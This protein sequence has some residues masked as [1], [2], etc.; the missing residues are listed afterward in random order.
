MASTTTFSR[1]SFLSLA[2][3]L[4]LAP[5]VRAAQ[6]F[7]RHGPP[8]LRLA[9]A[10]YSFRD[11]FQD[12]PEGAPAPAPGTRLLSLTDFLDF[13]A[14]HHCDGAEL[15]AYYFP[16]EVRESFLL[17]LRRHAFLR[18]V[19]LSGTAVG[20]TFTP[21]PGPRRDREIAHVKQWIEHA[22]VLGAPHLRVFA[23]NAGGSEPAEAR[24]RCIEALEDCA[25]SA[26]RA[27]VFLGIENHGGIVAEAGDLLDIVRAVRSPWV[28]INLDTGN[29]HTPDPYAD[30]ARCAPYAVNVQWKVEIRRRG[31]RPEPVDGPRVARILADAG[32]Q[33]WV[34]LEYESAED[35]FVA[36]PRHLDTL[37][38]LLRLE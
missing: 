34:A 4:A 29:F 12:R 11:F 38:H 5:A 13:C 22:R 30:L 36:V 32:Y 19:S 16:R 10:A 21:P 37:R 14:A 18:G 23:G 2:S 20:N 24:R 7:V 33:G 28:G 9:L 15:T 31:A 27:G 3:A 35:P 25:E 6:P 26:A 8:R 17:E 1:R